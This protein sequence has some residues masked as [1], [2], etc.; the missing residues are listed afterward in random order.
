MK[1]KSCGKEMTEL[2]ARELGGQCAECCHAYA[3]RYWE[4][5]KAGLHPMEHREG[6]PPIANAR[7]RR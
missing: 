1:C 2:E 5:I 6:P 3:K 4:E 7:R